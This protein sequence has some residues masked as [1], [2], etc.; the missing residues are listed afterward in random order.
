L[1]SPSRQATRFALKLWHRFVQENF[2]LRTKSLV[3]ATLFA[4]SQAPL[5]AQ[6]AAPAAPATPAKPA[7]PVSGQDK[8]RFK[9][10]LTSDALPDEA[11]AALKGAHGGFTVDSRPGKGE[12]YFHLRGAGLLQI[13]ADLKSV[14]L[15]PTDPAMKN[16][17]IHYSN[18]WYGPDGEA[19]LALAAND[20]AKVFTT[21]LDG[22]LLHTLEKPAA[23]QDLGNAKPNDYFAK[24][25]RFVPTGVD[26][27]DGRYYITTGYSEL[28]YVLTADISFKPFGAKWSD[29]SFGGKGKGIGQFG[30]GHAI[31][32]VPGTKRLD[33]A[34]RPNAEIERFSKYGHYQSTVRLPDGTFACDVDYL[35]NYAVVPALYAADRTKGAPLYLLENDKV[36]S[37]IMPK[38]ELGL[39]NFNSLHG[40]VLRES[41][42]KLFIIAQSWNPGDFAIL[43]QVTE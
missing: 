18:V 5:F 30:T 40:A 8:Y 23:G 36:V 12:T 39:R 3:A 16:V 27:L 38:E 1:L 17:N 22:K 7:V 33:V 29:L 37:T 11:K 10:A 2:M 34:D 13:S 28:D 26:Y 9:V 42:G 35:G 14:K 43:E 31:T 4:L 19:Y 6:D 15:L 32:R 20:V 24:N 41:N 25:G 21:D